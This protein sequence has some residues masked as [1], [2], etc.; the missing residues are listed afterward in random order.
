[1]DLNQTICMSTNELFKV[2]NSSTI[3]ALVLIIVL[4]LLAFLLY[5]AW[6]YAVTKANRYEKYIENTKQADKFI[7]YEKKRE[8]M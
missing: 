2:N 3:E 7:E 4:G 6:L 8:S 1:M 5:F